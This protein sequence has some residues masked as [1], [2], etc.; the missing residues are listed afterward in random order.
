MNGLEDFELAC[1]YCGEP[2]AL[3]VD[4]EMAGDTFIEDCRVCCRPMV[5]RLVG[6]GGGWRLEVRREDDP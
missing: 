4:L 1:P 2:Q 6:E 5:L 3:R